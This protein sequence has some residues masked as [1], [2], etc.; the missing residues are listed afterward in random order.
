M[1]ITGITSK[2][3]NNYN[4]NSFRITKKFHYFRGSHDAQALF[5][6]ATVLLLV[7]HTV[8]AQQQQAQS[9][10]TFV[11]DYSFCHDHGQFWET[12]GHTVLV[13]GS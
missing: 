1:D 3:P 2:L 8:T 7:C 11:L 4:P 6:V 13:F 10:A 5:M 9:C 12:V